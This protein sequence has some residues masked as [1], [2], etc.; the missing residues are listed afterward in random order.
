[1][2]QTSF[3]MLREKYRNAKAERNRELEQERK[4]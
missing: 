1:M 2:V 3:E 4:N